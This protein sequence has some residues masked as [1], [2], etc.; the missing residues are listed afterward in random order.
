VACAIEMQNTMKG[1][2]ELNHAQGLPALEMGIGLNETEV[3]VGNIGSSKRSK[4]AV[5]GSGVNMTSRIESYSVGGQILISESMRKKAGPVLRIDGQREIL[6]KGAETPLRIYDVGGLAGQYNLAL[7]EKDPDLATLTLK[8]PIL[9]TVLEGKSAEKKRLK[10]S[11]IR[12]SEK[13]AAM[14]LDEPLEPMTNLKIN[15]DDVEDRLAAYAFYG[16]IIERSEDKGLTH[17]LR[18]TSIPPEVDAYFK[19][20]LR[21]AEKAGTSGAHSVQTG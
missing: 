3:I 17:E 20:H 15:L 14:V 13:S 6:P 1:V 5:V 7:E 2:N 8:M 18:F 12:L 21:Y 11:L 4:Y 10:G 16:K 19:A 9:Y